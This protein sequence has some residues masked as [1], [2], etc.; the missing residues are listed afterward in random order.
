MDRRRCIGALAAGALAALPII[1][2]AQSSTRLRRIG[3]LSVGWGYAPLRS[4]YQDRLRQLGWT[5]G[6]NCVFV[7]K[8][9]EGDVARLDRLGAVSGWRFLPF[10]RGAQHE[11]RH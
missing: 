7:D 5:A 10:L 6:E 4:L 3:F 8:L 9:A 1:A 11:I 2:K